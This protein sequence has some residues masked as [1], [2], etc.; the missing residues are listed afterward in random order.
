MENLS[1]FWL[2]PWQVGTGSFEENVDRSQDAS[3]SSGHVSYSLNSLKGLH[4]GLNREHYKY[5]CY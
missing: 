3:Q 2:S 4:R 5:S 1:S